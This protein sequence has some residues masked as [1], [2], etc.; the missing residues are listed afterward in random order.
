[1]VSGEAGLRSC[2]VGARRYLLSGGDAAGSGLW[3]DRRVHCRLGAVSSN[4]SSIAVV[5]GGVRRLGFV[6]TLSAAASEQSRHWSGDAGDGDCHLCESRFRMRR[7]IRIKVCSTRI[8]LAKCHGLP[9]ASLCPM[10]SRRLTI[11]AMSFSSG[12]GASGIWPCSLIPRGGGSTS[13]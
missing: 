8:G 12:Y 4:E 3:Q 13:F 10:G 9:K 6:R 1:M 11:R 5:C 2:G 7:S